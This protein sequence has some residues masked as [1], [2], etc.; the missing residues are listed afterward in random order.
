MACLIVAG[1]SKLGFQHGS[2]TCPVLKYDFV[3]ARSTDPL[4]KA[5]ITRFV[6]QHLS[7]F[8]HLAAW[9]LTYQR[10]A[11]FLRK[12]GNT[13]CQGDLLAGLL[14]LESA[15]SP[16]SRTTTPSRGDPEVHLMIDSSHVP[17]R[18]LG[19]GAHFRPKSSCSDPEPTG[20]SLM[21]KALAAGK[22]GSFPAGRLL[23]CPK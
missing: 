10:S 8:H 14:D 4:A 15:P 12:H 22:Q 1:A 11:T 7:E 18:R 16:R 19:I 9:T 13:C 21:C 17:S 6:G 2:G 20:F 23:I 3:P 5:E